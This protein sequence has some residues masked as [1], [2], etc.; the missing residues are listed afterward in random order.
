MKE[1]KE[2][3]RKVS[4]SLD[5]SVMKKM[6]EC[7]CQNKIAVTKCGNGKFI[8]KGASGREMT[9]YARVSNLQVRVCM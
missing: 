1:S 3:I 9:T 5:V 2:K 4:E 7:T 8:V 6:A